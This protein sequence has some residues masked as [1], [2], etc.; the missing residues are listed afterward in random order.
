LERYLVTGGAGFI[1]SHIVE[2]LLEADAFVRVLDDFSSGKRENL[3]AAAKADHGNRLEVIEGD[4]RNAADVRDAVK[5]IK[6]VFH[7]A[8]F[9]SVP[10]SI[11]KPQDCFDVNVAGTSLLFETARRA[12]VQRVVIAS[13]AAVY[14]DSDGVPLDEGSPVKPLS[15]YA[16]SKYACEVYAGM[17][18]QAMSLEVVSLRYFNVYGPRQR[19]DS[20]YAAAVPIFIQRLLDGQAP[21]V[22]GDGKQ[23]RD[24]VFVGDVV[25]A[26]LAAANPAVRAGDVINVC[27]GTSTRILDLLQVLYDLLPGCPPPTFAEKR[28]GDIYESLG[29]AR[30]ARSALNFA[31]STALREGMQE[32]IACMR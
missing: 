2:K 7:E 18:S 6:T 24:L 12:G 10:E 31:A 13:S 4:I 8:A 14:G 17:Y 9:V 26:N 21:T 28:A 5:D 15:P 32:T 23:S 25:R 27:T 11:E 19:P 29:D 20:P 30:K 16:A 3:E 22:F 1:G